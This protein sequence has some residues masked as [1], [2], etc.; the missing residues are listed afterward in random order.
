MRL[1]FILCVLLLIVSTTS[2]DTGIGTGMVD[3]PPDVSGGYESTAT[4]SYETP[5][6]VDAT[7]TGGDGVD[8]EGEIRSAVSSFIDDHVVLISALATTGATVVALICVYLISR[9]LR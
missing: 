8:I 2:A 6:P 1:F 4:G 9:I 7:A 3:G 5:G